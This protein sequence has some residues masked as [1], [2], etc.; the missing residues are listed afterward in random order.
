MSPMR[1]M[2]FALLWITLGLP[3]AACVNNQAPVAQAP[4]DDQQCQ[5]MG[6]KLGTTNYLQCRQLMLNQQAANEAS[7]PRETSIGERLRNA[8][9]ALRAAGEQGPKTTSCLP[10]AGGGLNCTTF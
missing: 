8:G 7:R 2:R 4:T 1:F 3:L 6:Y 5:A 9:A 10:T